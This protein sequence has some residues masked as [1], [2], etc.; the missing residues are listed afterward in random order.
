MAS[1]R[2]VTKNSAQGGQSG[3]SIPG[4]PF[5]MPPYHASCFDSSPMSGELSQSGLLAQI[6][7]G[8]HANSEGTMMSGPSATDL[9]AAAKKVPEIVAENTGCIEEGKRQGG[10]VIYVYTVF[11][12]F[13]FSINEKIIMTMKVSQNLK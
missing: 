1:F 7:E 5:A 4:F 6:S 2:V 11:F 12:F 8:R 9:V 13:F 3:Y 10:R